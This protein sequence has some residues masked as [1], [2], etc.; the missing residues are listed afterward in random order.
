MTSSGRQNNTYQNYDKT[1]LTQTKT[2]MK[3]YASDE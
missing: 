3:S 1:T 2:D